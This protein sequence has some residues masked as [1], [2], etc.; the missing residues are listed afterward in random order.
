MRISPAFHLLSST[1]PPPKSGDRF[2]PDSTPLPFLRNSPTYCTSIPPRSHRHATYVPRRRKSSLSGR[3]SASPYYKSPSCTS[4]V[5]RGPTSSGFRRSPGSNHPR[6]H[7]DPLYP[8]TYSDDF[9][10]PLDVVTPAHTHAPQQP[11]YCSIIVFWLSRVR[12][13]R[14][15]HRRFPIAEQVR[16]TACSSLRRRFLQVI[17]SG[18]C[19]V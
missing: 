7:G 11:T 19:D 13:V 18:I 6:H 8:M 12:H 4:I 17:S 3:G 14:A 5:R 9:H 2:H 1:F 10:T 16:H 15:G